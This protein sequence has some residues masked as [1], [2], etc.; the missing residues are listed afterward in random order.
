MKKLVLAAFMVCTFLFVGCSKNDSEKTSLI[1]GTWYDSYTNG[2]TTECFY[3]D[4]SWS[5]ES[6][7]FYPLYGTYSFD[8]K[9]RVLI[10]NVTPS[11]NNGGGMRT[12]YVL[13]LTSTNLSYSDGGGV[14][15][16]FV[17]AN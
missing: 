11:V 8:E 3:A 4:G 6:G 7:L 2:G 1:V 12:Y 10:I 16:N 15:N 14:V 17:R 13:A 5:S 9:T